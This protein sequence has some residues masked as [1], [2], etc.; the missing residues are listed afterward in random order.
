MRP[1]EREHFDH[2]PE[3]AERMWVRVV[4]ALGA[5]ARH[6]TKSNASGL[7]DGRLF[8]VPD[9]RP[10][11]PGSA[12]SLPNGIVSAEEHC[13]TSDLPRA[14]SS[15]MTGVPRKHLLADRNEG[16]FLASVECEGK[17]FGISKVI[18]SVIT[19]QGQDALV[20]DVPAAAIEVLRLTCPELVR[21]L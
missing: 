20:T 15:S 14:L 8:V 17:W 5:R 21:I 2:S 7:P 12:G 19:S 11:D 9:A 4:D 16:R 3:W 13:Y 10:A 6:E 18:L 1:G